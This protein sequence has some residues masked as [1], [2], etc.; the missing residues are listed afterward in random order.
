MGPIKQTNT[1]IGGMNTDLDYSVIKNNQYMYAE[2]IRLLANT[3]NSFSAIQNIEGFLN[4]DNSIP[5]GET[6]IH[7]KTV[8]DYGIVFTVDRDYN[9]SVYR[10]DFS[11]SKTYPQVT[12]IISKVK[13]FFFFISKVYGV[14]IFFSSFLFSFSSFNLS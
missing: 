13:F 6:I 9:N 10:F 14:L 12:K 3:D 1:F 8:R 4:I 11:E 2:N 7:T 5:T